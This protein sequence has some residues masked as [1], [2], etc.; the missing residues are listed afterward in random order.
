MEI[1]REEEKRNKYSGIVM[2]Y[3]RRD[4]VGEGFGKSKVGDKVLV[5][6]K[7][8]K[9]DWGNCDWRK[10]L[11]NYKEKEEG[12]L[13]RIVRRINNGYYDYWYKVELKDGKYI[14]RSYV[15]LI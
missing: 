4:K 7:Y 5:V 3:S 14:W 1:V 8:K 10:S 9:I 15:E 12:V 2:K 6:V 11:E 13:R